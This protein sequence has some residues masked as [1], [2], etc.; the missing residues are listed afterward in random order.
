MDG[1]Y[2]YYVPSVRFHVDDNSSEITGWELRFYTWSPD[3]GSYE[4][5]TGVEEMLP[6]VGHFSVGYDT[7]NPEVGDGLSNVS[8]GEVNDFEGVSV[9]MDATDDGPQLSNFAVSY[10]TT[11]TVAYHFDL[12][13]RE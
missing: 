4:L 3:D 11:P 1:N 8:V 5:V 9:Y 10:T 2:R 7:H 6:I 12:W 13:D